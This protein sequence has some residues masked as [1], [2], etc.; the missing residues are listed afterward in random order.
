MLFAA[1]TQTRDTRQE[2]IECDAFVTG[3]AKLLN[4][5]QI[6]NNTA[7][8]QKIDSFYDAKNIRCINCLVREKFLVKSAIYFNELKYDACTL[9][10]DRTARAH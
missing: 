8:I 3:K 10:V 1:C 7:F 5:G 9:R 4:G 2:E 6:A